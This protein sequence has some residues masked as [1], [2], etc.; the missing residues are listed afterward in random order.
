MRVVFSGF[1]EQEAA[2][3]VIEQLRGLGV[4]SE[5]LSLVTSAKSKLVQD[6]L[7]EPAEGETG[8]G[9]LIGGAIGTLLGMLGG[10]T[11][12]TIAGFGEALAGGLL[13]TVIGGTIG[14]YLGGIYGNRAASEDELNVKEALMQGDLLVIVGLDGNDQEAIVDTIEQGGAEFVAIH[15]METPYS[16]ITGEGEA[17]GEEILRPKA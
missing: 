6:L 3:Q 7:N 10:A 2:Q 17:S 8:Q 15:E 11:M 4:P 13:A 16:G 1:K 9:M 5:D 14:T 12:F